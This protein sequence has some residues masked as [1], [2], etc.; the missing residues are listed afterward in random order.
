MAE[1]NIKK[2]GLAGSDCPEV[3]VAIKG[4]IKTPVNFVIPKATL[5]QGAAA[6]ITYLNTQALLGNVDKFPDFQALEDISQE[7]VYQDTIFSISPVKDGNYRFRPTIASSLCQHKAMF[8]HRSKNFRAFLFDDDG[9]LIG[10]EKTN[11]DMAG[12]LGDLLHTEKMRFN[13][14][15][16]ASVSPLMV[17]FKNNKEWDRYG[18][19]ID[20]SQG[21]GDIYQLVDAVV[22]ILADPV[23]TANVIVV[24]VTTECD[25][26][27]VEGLVEADFI[28]LDAD[29]VAVVLTDFEETSPGVYTLTSTADFVDNGTVTIKPASTITVKPI[30]VY[31]DPAVITIP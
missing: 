25:G 15:T 30:A 2:K 13:N 22:E 3:P 24:E 21:L 29:G 23:P 4:M 20:I 17:A 1:C 11:G 10:T 19:M 12:W 9:W 5:D 7:Q 18:I 26:V 31:N 28:V 14:G 16:E 6:V 8:T 27:A